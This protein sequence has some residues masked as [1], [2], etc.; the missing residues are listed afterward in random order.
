MPPPTKDGRRVAATGPPT[1]APGLPRMSMYTAFTP[2]PQ[3]APAASCS[4]PATGYR[5]HHLTP[6]QG[7]PAASSRQ[8]PQCLCVSVPGPP[9]SRPRCLCVGRRIRP[10]GPGRPQSASGCGCA[11]GGPSRCGRRALCPGIGQPAD[12]SRSGNS[13]CA[14]VP[15]CPGLLLPVSLLVLLLPLLLLLLS[16]CCCCCCYLAGGTAPPAAAARSGDR[17]SVT[18]SWS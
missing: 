1:P 2:L 16:H 17:G 15:L 14:A 18:S 3:R 13:L 12:G 11:N 10:T 6:R 5:R 9:P 7:A 4:C 8:Q